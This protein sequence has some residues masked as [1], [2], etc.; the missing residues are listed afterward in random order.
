MLEKQPPQYVDQ[1]KVKT[2]AY[3]QAEALGKGA[4]CGILLNT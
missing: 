1:M 4:N 2:R 3:A